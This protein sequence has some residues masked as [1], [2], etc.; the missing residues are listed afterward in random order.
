MK[1]CTV[2]SAGSASGATAPYAASASS[3]RPPAVQPVGVGE[4][5]AGGVPFRD[6]RELAAVQH[7]VDPYLV[8]QPVE[9]DGED[10]QHRHERV[11]E[12]T[13]MSPGRDGGR[14]GRRRG[15]LR[16]HRR[17]DVAS[18][19]MIRERQVYHDERSMSLAATSSESPASA[20]AR[21]AADRSRRPMVSR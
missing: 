14:G 11:E 3:S 15:A 12:P 17:E 21:Q 4:P 2:R 1:R 10:R 7:R 13:A 20:T 19:R 18:L 16:Q 6:G 8:E 9:I 5:A